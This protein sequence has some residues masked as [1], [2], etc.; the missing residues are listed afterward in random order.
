[1]EDSDLY[2]FIMKVLQRS[3]GKGGKCE[4]PNG[5]GMD[6][7]E[8]RTPRLPTPTPGSTARGGDRSSRK[9]SITT[10]DTLAEIFKKIGHREDTREVSV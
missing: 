3:G 10:H 7:T 8:E 6:G 9:L 5:A 1:M 2:A 4:T